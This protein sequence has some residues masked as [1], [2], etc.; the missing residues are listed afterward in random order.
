MTNQ[1]QDQ[2]NFSVAGIQAIKANLKKQIKAKKQQDL[3]KN[4]KATAQY[5][6]NWN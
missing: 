1:A 4:I 5:F 6:D 2:I 3:A